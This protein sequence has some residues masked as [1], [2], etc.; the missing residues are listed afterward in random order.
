MIKLQKNA[1]FLFSYFVV[2]HA[3]AKPINDDILFVATYTANTSEGIYRLHF[4]KDNGKLYNP[5]LAAGISNPSWLAL[6]KR[7]SILYAVSENSPD[8]RDNIGRA[9]SYQLTDGGEL[10]FLNRINTLGDEPTHASI[11]QDERYLFISNYAAESPSGGS[12]SVAPID[13]NGKLEAI[14]Q[15]SS[16]RA[17]QANKKRQL[18]PHVHSTVMT[19]DNHYVLACDLGADKIYIYHYNPSKN[20][21]HPLFSDSSDSVHFAP[22]TGPRHILFNKNGKNLYVTLEMSG[23]VATLDYKNGKLAIKQIVNLTDS[24][25]PERK[26]ASALHISKD[27]RFLYVSNR[28]KS[29]EINV[30]AINPENGTLKIIQRY[31]SEG[32]TPREF[33]LDPSN[34]YIL[35]ANQDSNEII[36]MQR[37]QKTGKIVATLQRFTIDRP[38]QLLFLE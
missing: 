32:K 29:N 3:I 20:S 9:S 14:T 35:V 6:N 27:N 34:R 13:P 15:I 10:S 17:S 4:N 23:Q 25:D 28:G 24:T 5:Q 22:G 30:F 16:H 2:I 18:T 1:L 8:S 7:K 37:D 12:L 11:S 36:V 33:T 21:E 38:T 19:P 26:S 31:S